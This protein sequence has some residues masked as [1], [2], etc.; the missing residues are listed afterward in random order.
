MIYGFLIFYVIFNAVSLIFPTFIPGSKCQDLRINLNFFHDKRIIRG[1]G[2][3]SG[4]VNDA[5]SY[6]FKGVYT[7]PHSLFNEFGFIFKYLPSVGIK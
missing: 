6:L 5:V 1:N 7:A 2:L 3:G 4:I